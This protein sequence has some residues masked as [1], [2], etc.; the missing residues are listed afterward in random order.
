L[1]FKIKINREEVDKEYFLKEIQPNLKEDM[2][3]EQFCRSIVK[4]AID[5]E[6]EAW[7]LDHQDATL[8]SRFLKPKDRSTG[9][10]KNERLAQ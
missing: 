10:G 2:T 7:G 3:F 1:S 4:P 5:R 6:L 8:F 9:G